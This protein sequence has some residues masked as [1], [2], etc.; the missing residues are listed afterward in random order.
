MSKEY[1]S[2]RSGSNPNANG[3]PLSDLLDLFSRAYTL[4]VNDGY[5]SEA[6][7][8][9]CV[10]QGFVPGKVKDPAL[11]ILLAI[12]KRDLWPVTSY[13]Y[14]YSEDD[15]FDV[16]EFLYEQVSEPIEGTYHKHDNCGMHW[17]TYDQNKG[18]FVFR[19]R[20]NALLSQ[21]KN[22]FELSELGE[23]LHKPDKGFE[24]IFEAKIPTED[25]KVR[26]KIE[27]AAIKY[28]KHG[29]TIEDRKLAV[30]DLADVL[31]YLR[32][33]IREVLNRKDENDLFNIANNFGIRHY[34]EN[35]K[36]NYDESIW[37]SWMFYFFLSTI[38]VILRTSSQV[39]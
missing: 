12:R 14:D 5:F 37:L 20:I 31:E 15:L 2:I 24:A 16:I 23:I 35:Q 38:H 13:V 10:D 26:L 11:E 28:R 30:R 29:S 25:Q 1:F 8:F 7:G 33:T 3:L 9:N 19:E 4:L 32:P 17:E 34:G 36:T 39:K 21:Y 18:K 22:R 27:A 6:F